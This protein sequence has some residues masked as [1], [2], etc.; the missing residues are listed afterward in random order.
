[1]G[2]ISAHGMGNLYIWKAYYI[3]ILY[4]DVLEEQM[5]IV[6][7]PVNQLMLIT[8]QISNFRRMAMATA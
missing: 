2:F 7:T 8:N 5:S 3:Y 6:V 1:M 4:K